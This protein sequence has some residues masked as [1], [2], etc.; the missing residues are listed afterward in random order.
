ME[1]E[2]LKFSKEEGRNIVYNDYPDFL[3]VEKFVESTSRWST[4]YRII[5][6]R[7]SDGKFFESAYSEGSTEMQ[8]ESPYEY[9]DA[10]FSE[11]VPLQKTI[12]YYGWE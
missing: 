1:R 3:I 2:I 12:T 8:D 11:V 4:Y 9:S 10:E 7:K 5:V 6:K